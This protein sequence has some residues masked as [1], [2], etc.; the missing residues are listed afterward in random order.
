MLEIFK[1]IAK[2]RVEKVQRYIAQQQSL[3][4]MHQG[5]TLLFFAVEHGS[6]NV[7]FAS[8]PE[9][10]KIVTLLLRAG[11]PVNSQNAP[12]VMDDAT[13]TPALT[14]IPDFGSATA[15]HIAAKK[16][17]LKMLQ[18]LIAAGANVDAQNVDG[19]TPLLLACKYGKFSIV[20]ALLQAG[21]NKDLTDDKTFTPVHRA[22]ENKN[23]KIAKLLVAQGADCTIHPV[24]GWSPLGTTLSSNNMVMFH[25]LL[26]VITQHSA[27]DVSTLT[28]IA[29]TRKNLEVL[30]LLDQAGFTLTHYG[31]AQ[32]CRG[33]DI[34]MLRFFLDK[35]FSPNMVYGEDQESPLH[36][37]IQSRFVSGVE[38]LIKAGANVNA[39][40]CHGR[41]PIY[42]AVQDEEMGTQFVRYVEYW[43]SWKSHVQLNGIGPHS[44]L[45]FFQNRP[46]KMQY[47]RSRGVFEIKG[48][49]EVQGLLLQDT[50]HDNV[51]VA[52][53][54]KASIQRLKVGKSA[55]KISAAYQELKTYFAT[56]AFEA[57]LRAISNINN[58]SWELDRPLVK[59]AMEACIPEV[60][61]THLRREVPGLFDRMESSANSPDIRKQFM[62][63][64]GLMWLALQED[65][66]LLI[67]HKPNA[68]NAEKQAALVTFKKDMLQLFLQRLFSFQYEYYQRGSLEIA[69]PACSMG[70]VHHILSSFN[71]LHAD[72]TVTFLK[73]DPAYSPDAALPA[74][75]KAKMP[76]LVAKAYC[77]V[78]W[79]WVTARADLELTE[80][81][82][83]A[84]FDTGAIENP[85]HLALAQKALGRLKATVNWGAYNVLDAPEARRCAFIALE[86]EMKLAPLADW[87][88]WVYSAKG[89]TAALLEAPQKAP[90][91]ETW[92]FHTKEQLK[93][94]AWFCKLTEKQKEKV[95]VKLGKQ[96]PKPGLIERVKAW[97]Y[98]TI[99]KKT[100][101][102]LIPPLQQPL[103]L[104]APPPIMVSVPARNPTVPMS[105]AGRAALQ[106]Q[107]AQEAHR[108]VSPRIGLGVSNH[109]LE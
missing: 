108:R 57:E 20:V 65:S 70:T 61:Y 56:E 11:C 81:Q 27:N 9:S 32:A 38:L 6:F 26:G 63:T 29:V 64:A 88:Q 91:L 103:L 50:A 71:G 17:N 40:D 99:H 101:V 42:K 24:G 95:L 12:G 8:D 67:P 98:K 10:F 53:S 28:S 16:G 83:L 13:N 18:L 5:A 19:A 75:V 96:A 73:S 22:L 14:Y 2:S 43:L 74:R 93:E 23:N 62:K 79:A 1:D 77:P 68:T 7:L 21:A 104:E 85:K 100:I 59:A 25:V 76:E 102:P 54:F 44:I 39:K 35:G 66:K 90:M 80:E 72:V 78:L 55:S 49:A 33:P 109:V 107:Q 4:V 82:H 48:N 60:R 31:F 97:I 105:E 87:L 106:R 45:C 34:Y 3:E 36:R 92:Q 30:R 47:W 41:T 86:Q 46:N 89:Y 69:H 52:E 84:F 15:L 51:Q 37:A 58:W 94:Q